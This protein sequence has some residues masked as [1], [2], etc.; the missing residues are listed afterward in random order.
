MD[1]P[2][3]YKIFTIKTLQTG[4]IDHLAD[5]IYF[6]GCSIRCPY[7]FNKETWTEGKYMSADEISAQL[8][9]APYVCFMG[10]EPLD[11][12][13]LSLLNALTPKKR[14]LFTGFV[15]NVH[16][17][18]HV[19]Y[20]LKPFMTYMPV[21]FSNRHSFGVV[22]QPSITQEMIHEWCRCMDLTSCDFYIKG[23]GEHTRLKELLQREGITRIFGGVD[24]IHV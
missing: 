4:D 3:K 14:V 5:S 19:H 11:Q 17:F 18:D 22:D 15:M 12:P 1:L 20:D 7:C 9:D 24:V 23:I 13:L 8:S 6:S 16:R 10:G 2:M 21:Y